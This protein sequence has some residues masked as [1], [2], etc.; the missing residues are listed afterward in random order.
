MIYTRTVPGRFHNTLN[1]GIVGA[2][3]LQETKLVDIPLMACAREIWSKISKPSRLRVSA[4]NAWKKRILQLDAGD[5]ATSA[6]T[7]FFRPRSFS[8]I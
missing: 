7:V 8:L 5:N 4:H 6:S 1:H 3:I 2:L